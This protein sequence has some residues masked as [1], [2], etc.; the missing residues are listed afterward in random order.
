MHVGT[1]QQAKK[2]ALIA[3]GAGLAVIVLVSI[4]AFVAR[5]V[6]DVSTVGLGLPGRMLLL[7]IL[8]V[9]LGFIPKMPGKGF[10]AGLGVLLLMIGIFGLFLLPEI[11]V[12]QERKAERVAA[13]QV[14]IRA[15]REPQEF[16]VNAGETVSTI[17]IEGGE[18]YDACTN[19]RWR[20]GRQSIHEIPAG[21]LC[22]TGPGRVWATGLEDGTH[23]RF[24]ERRRS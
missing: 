14:A 21:C 11:R 22:I 20:M 19:R 5:S 2:V 8:L 7:G 10:L 13:A 9:A 17:Y 12:S 23:I 18:R 4:I 24:T 16:T 15:A 1:S 3:A 6:G